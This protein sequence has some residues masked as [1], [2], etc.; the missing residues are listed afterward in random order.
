MNDVS[1]ALGA[2]LEGTRPDL[3]KSLA[4]ALGP[5]CSDPGGTPS[6]EECEDCAGRMASALIGDGAPAAPSV[7]GFVPG[8][9][10]EAGRIAG[11][12]QGFAAAVWLL[13]A[14]AAGD[15]GLRLVDEETC[16][17]YERNVARLGEL[18]EEWR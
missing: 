18:L 14:L 11:W 15:S 1:E 13:P 12:L 7:P 4:A 8:A 9:R 2:A 5:G 3:C 17:E 16:M 6:A 10:A